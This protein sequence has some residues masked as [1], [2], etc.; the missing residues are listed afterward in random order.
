[1]R[2]ALEFRHSLRINVHGHRDVRV[3]YELLYRFDIFAI[4][5][6]Q[7]GKGVPESMPT[8]LL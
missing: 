6:E 5:L 8:D 1:M 3:P 2:V 4:R 7:R